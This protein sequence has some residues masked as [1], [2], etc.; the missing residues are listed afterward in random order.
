MRQFILIL[1]FTFFIIPFTQSQ[2]KKGD[3]FTEF[4]DS[5]KKGVLNND[6]Q[7]VLKMTNLSTVSDFTPLTEKSFYEDYDNIFSD[8]IKTF[9][10]ANPKKINANTPGF[11]KI[12]IGG[13]FIKA[14]SCFYTFKKINGRWLLYNKGCPG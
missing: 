4:W 3:G 1:A 14:N 7:T 13:Y 10:R 2:E 12:L 5:F 11:D 6:K 9:Q 8:V